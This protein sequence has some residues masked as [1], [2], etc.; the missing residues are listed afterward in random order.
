MFF[1]HAIR[2]Y[3]S[4]WLRIM[5]CSTW[6]N[7]WVIGSLSTCIWRVGHDI[8]LYLLPEVGGW[9]MVFGH[10]SSNGLQYFHY[11]ARGGSWFFRLYMVYWHH[12]L[13]LES[14]M[15]MFYTSV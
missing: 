5:F 8:L 13:F 14:L 2:S 11:I 12:K 4:T 10:A 15:V 6:I 9:V 1:Q 7:G 3:F